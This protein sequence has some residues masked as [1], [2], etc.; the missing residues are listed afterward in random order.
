MSLEDAIRRTEL[1]NRARRLSPATWAWITQ[2]LHLLS[3]WCGER[4]IRELSQLDRGILQEYL[5]G[6]SALSAYTVR[7]DLAA[8]HSLFRWALE[9]GVVDQDI[10]KG[11]KVPR[12]PTPHKLPLTSE[13]IA[14]LLSAFDPRTYT[15]CRDKTIVILLLDTGLRASELVHLDVAD[16]DTHG[17]WIRVRN[18][19]GEEQRRVPITPLV[20]SRVHTYCVGHRPVPVGPDRIFLTWHGCPMTRERLAKV[21]IDAG[22]RAGL[23][24]YPH[25]LRHTFATHY[26]RNSGDVFSLQAVL[27]HAS[28]ATTRRYVDVDPAM[29]EAAHAR[30]SPMARLQG[31]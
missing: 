23:E 27:G 19:K 1:H 9:D 16:L 3:R 15:G 6:R 30:A 31:L 2:K 18:G 20:A 25:L 24:V 29:V 26:V 13:E 11:L 14:R 21:I 7:G 5:A 10:S 22:K 8:I 4:G 12:L 17:F 28:I